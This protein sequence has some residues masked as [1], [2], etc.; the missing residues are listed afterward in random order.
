[1]RN[2]LPCTIGTSQ[3]K[4]VQSKGW[5]SIE[6]YLTFYPWGLEYRIPLQ[7]DDALDFLDDHLNEGESRPYEVR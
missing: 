5:L 6:S 1:M 2:S 7:A 4:V 3:T